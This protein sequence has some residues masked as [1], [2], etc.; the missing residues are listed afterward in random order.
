MTQH[1]DTPVAAA[2]THPGRRIFL[3]GA[4]AG[5]AAATGLIA[6]GAGRAVAAPGGFPD[7]RHLKP[8]LT[9]SRLK[10]NPTGEI[11]FPCVRGV[12]DKL[13]NPLGRYY[14]YY[15]THDAPGGICLAYGDSLE[16]PFTTTSPTTATSPG[17]GRRTAVTGPSPSSR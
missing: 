10:Y 16:G 7:Y 11:I 8:L 5:T 3:R 4:I 14:L 9:P 13:A 15:A 1:E 6:T 2:A 17:A 12:Y